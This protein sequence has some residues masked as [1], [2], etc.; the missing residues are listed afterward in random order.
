MPKVEQHL[1]QRFTHMLPGDRV[2]WQRFLIRHGEYYDR[3]E[4]D[5]HLG[6]GVPIS[7]AWPEWV[8]R[9]AKALTRKRV[10]VVGYRADEVWIFEVKPDAGLSAVGQL[11]GYKALWTK[12]RGEPGRLY[13]AVVTDRLNPD[14]EFLFEHYGIRTYVVV[15]A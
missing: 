5:V 6:E 15:P 9:A 3:F 14:E 13:L 2:L 1:Q 10:D 8:Q 12:E 11:L 4:Y 7:A